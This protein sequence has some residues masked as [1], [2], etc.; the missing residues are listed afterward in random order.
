MPVIGGYDEYRG[1]IVMKDMCRYVV[2]YHVC[3]L[4]LLFSALVLMSWRVGRWIGVNAK[5]S[6]TACVIAWC[7]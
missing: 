2:I 3:M 5:R 7:H 6:G 4:L 1:C